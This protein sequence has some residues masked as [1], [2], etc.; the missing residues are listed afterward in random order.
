[1]RLSIQPV[2]KGGSMKKIFS[3]VFILMFICSLIALS[4]GKASAI[5]ISTPEPQTKTWEWYAKGVEGV[6]IPMYTI[7]TKPK[8]WYQLKSDGL[9][10]NGASGICYPFDE[11]RHGWTGEIFQR[12]GGDWVMLVTTVGWVP[13]AEG[14]YKACA[15]APAAGEYALFA[16]FTKPAPNP[17]DCEAVW[18]AFDGIGIRD[19][20]YLSVFGGIDPAKF[21]HVRVVLTFYDVL[22]AGTIDPLRYSTYTDPSGS[23][24]FGPIYVGT[25]LYRWKLTLGG[26]SMP[27]F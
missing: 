14:N 22:P 16:Y 2:Q 9:K 8:E 17:V 20:G 12:V 15:Q 23:F 19:S 26:C 21:Q 1:M 27:S 10:I 13:D 25:S 7:T 5:G 6:E 18:A 11:G 24:V 3:F 4:P